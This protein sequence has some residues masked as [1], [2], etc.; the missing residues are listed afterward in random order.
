[1]VNRRRPRATKKERRT[2]TAHAGPAKGTARRHGRRSLA[3]ARSHACSCCS[4]AGCPS[5][6]FLREAG[7][8]LARQSTCT[9]G[10]ARPVSACRDSPMVVVPPFPTRRIARTHT[11]IPRRPPGNYLPSPWGRP[12]SVARLGDYSLVAPPAKEKPIPRHKNG[13]RV[14]RAIRESGTMARGTPIRSF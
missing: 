8:T 3:G 10:L 7:R 2:T 4:R 12:R 14:G 1:M 5:W 9:N 13:G 6:R 11:L